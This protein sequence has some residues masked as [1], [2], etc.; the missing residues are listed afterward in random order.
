MSVRR[1]YNFCVGAVCSVACM[2]FV[3]SK[4][5]LCSAQIVINE[6]V[7]S[8]VKTLVD[9]DGDSSDWLELFNPGDDSVNIAGFALS[10][11]P[12]K[13]EKWIFPD[14]ILQPQSFLVVFASNKNRRNADQLHTNFKINA[15]GETLV[16]TAPAGAVADS[17]SLPP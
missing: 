7:S 10:D 16:L 9:E 3:P 15:D 1:L 4:D 8:N 12:N 5:V 6:I 14:L 17:V 2:M 11:N 13:P